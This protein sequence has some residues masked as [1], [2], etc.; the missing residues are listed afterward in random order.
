ME[1]KTTRS[2]EAL[3]ARVVTPPDKGNPARRKAGRK[4]A[5]KNRVAGRR[6]VSTLKILGK[7]GAFLLILAF[8][9]SV[10]VYAYTS[11]KFNLRQVTFYGCKELNKRE[12]EEVIRKDFPA[13]ILRIDLQKLKER[14]EKETWAKRVEI[15]RVLPSDLIIYV[16]ERTPSVIL[17]LHGELMVAD[18]DGTM[19]GRYDPRFGKLDVPVFKG[20]LGDDAEDCKLYQEE[21]ATRIHQGL[22]MLSQIEAGLPHATQKISE[23][24]IS[25]PENL[26]ILLVDDTAEVYLGEKDYLKRFRTLMSNLGEYQKLKDQYTEFVSIDVRFDNQIVYL[27]KRENAE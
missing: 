17:E 5:G 4:L 2:R 21:N 22:V 16:E 27:P 20:V 7:V 24:D 25:D 19:L 10:F 8:M 26:K 6:F 15:R 18:Q 23:V 12:L 1:I 9:L 14:L 11:E 3:N 13:N